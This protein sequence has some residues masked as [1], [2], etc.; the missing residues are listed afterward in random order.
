LFTVKGTDGP[1]TH[2]ITVRRL[3][4][5]V[6]ESERLLPELRPD[7]PGGDSIAVRAETLACRD[8]AATDV[9]VF[10]RYLSESG[11]RG[12]ILRL[13]P[14]QDLATLWEGPAPLSAAFGPGGA[15]AYLNLAP[16]GE[17]EVSAL[18]LDAPGEHRPIARVPAGSGPMVASPDGRR[19][20]TV[21]VGS[22]RPS[23]VVTVD[24]AAS[25]PAVS[26]ADLGGAG[27][28]G[29][30][31]WVGD[32]LV[33]MPALRPAEAVRIY[34]PGL[35]TVLASWAGWTAEHSVVIGERLY[36]ASQGAV[37]SAP[38]TTGTASLVQELEDALVV[39]IAD[40]SPPAAESPAPAPTTTTTRT[41]PPVVAT[42]TTTAPKT[43]PT[44]TTTVPAEATTTTALPQRA[45]ETR[46]EVAGRTATKGDGGGA[47]GVLA[48]VGVLVLV[49][50]GGVVLRVRRRRRETLDSDFSKRLENPFPK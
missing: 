5:M 46:P 49:A 27:V 30:V 6:T 19:L 44:T 22:S 40:V 35:T 31:Q 28:A 45:P 43:S 33:F 50:G 14:G 15:T 4:T 36:G 39:S 25:P 2:G 1:D 26:V 13:V 10:A 48:L 18:A 7:P 42:T 47:G 32:R 20:A 41:A 24:L 9:V 17:V 29:D 12:R 3:D 23:Q 16:L 37:R 8:A 21:A 11:D 34:D 38:L